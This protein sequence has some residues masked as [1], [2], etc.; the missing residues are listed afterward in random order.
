MKLTDYI[1][2]FIDIP[3]GLKEFIFCNA[4]TRIVNKGE[5]L[6]KTR[7]DYE[8]FSGSVLFVESGLMRVFFSKNDKQLTMRFLCENDF[9]FSI[10][11]NLYNKKA[12]CNWEA[13]E[14]T[15]ICFFSYSIFEDALVKFREL[16]RFTRV[17]LMKSML[18][19]Q[20]LAFA[21]RTLSA[22]Q[23][24]DILMLEKPEIF[25]HAPVGHV[26]SYLGITPQAMSILRSRYKSVK[27]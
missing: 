26:A 20:Q 23:R 21:N 25:L 14:E 16:E 8:T 22:Q 9:S 27:K 11:K 17:E 7:A 6:V 10:E 4:H 5:I 13:L 19:Y 3:P 24:F 1:S 18:E 15:N 2:S 12:L